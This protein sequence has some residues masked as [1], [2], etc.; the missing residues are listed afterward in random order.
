MRNAEVQHPVLQLGMIGV[1]KSCS[2]PY[3]FD[4]GLNI[5][6]GKPAKSLTLRVINTKSCSS[7]VAASK[8]S[9]AGSGRRALRKPFNHTGISRLA[10][11]FGQDVDVNQVAQNMTSR[12]T[13]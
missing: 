13:L 11:Q 9:M 4:Q 2:V 5:S 7:A 12:V 3:Q 1:W 10:A 8:L 6:T